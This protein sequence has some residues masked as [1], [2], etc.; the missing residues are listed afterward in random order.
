MK[1]CI[2]NTCREPLITCIIKAI[3][4]NFNSLWKFR[5][6]ITLGIVLMEL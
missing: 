1:K 2:S 5:G 3:D 4:G 6:L